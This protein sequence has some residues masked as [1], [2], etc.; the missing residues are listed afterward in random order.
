MGRGLDLSDSEKAK[1]DAWVLD[2][3]ALSEI[4]QR[5][6]RHHSCISRYINK[7]NSPTG[8]AKAGR[9]PK[10]TNR[11]HRRIFDLATNEDLSLAQIISQAKLEVSKSTVLRS[12]NQNPNV[13]RKK[14][15]ARPAMKKRHI[16][17]RKLW[18]IE[19]Q[20]W[21]EKWKK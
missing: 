13:E 3:I 10:L 12:L 16:E 21:D 1:I 14:R 2:K 7:K 9:K 17:A 5:L 11:D 8:R 19:H 4:A 18:A 6:N 15:R 20:T